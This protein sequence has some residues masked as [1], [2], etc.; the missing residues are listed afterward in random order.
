[1]TIDLKEKLDK[2]PQVKMKFLNESTAKEV[3][4][5]LKEHAKNNGSLSLNEL[6]EIFTN[7]YGKK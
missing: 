6:D 2:N 1:M 4:D 3:I 5:G 7:S